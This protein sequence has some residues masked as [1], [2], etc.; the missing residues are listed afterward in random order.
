VCVC[1]PLFST[2]LRYTRDYLIN[3]PV[4]GSWMCALPRGSHLETGRSDWA[5]GATGA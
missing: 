2:G 4:P 3:A 5:D 1:V